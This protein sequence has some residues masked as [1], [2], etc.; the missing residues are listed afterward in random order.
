MVWSP[1]ASDDVMK[2]KSDPKPLAVELLVIPRG[3]F[4]SMKVTMPLGATGA[5]DAAATCAVKVTKLPANDG[6][7][8]EDTVVSEFTLSSFRLSSTSNNARWL[9]GRRA[10]RRELRETV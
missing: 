8:E 7:S 10:D 4:P 6:L 5:A 1:G 3:E 2:V 9:E